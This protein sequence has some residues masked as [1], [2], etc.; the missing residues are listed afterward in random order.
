[1]IYAEFGGD[2]INISKVTIRKTKSD[3]Y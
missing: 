1:L 3:N 2:L